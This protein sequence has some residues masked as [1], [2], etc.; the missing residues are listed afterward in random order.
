VIKK[1]IANQVR[2]GKKRVKDR[3]LKPAKVRKRGIK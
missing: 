1:I 2:K 3:L